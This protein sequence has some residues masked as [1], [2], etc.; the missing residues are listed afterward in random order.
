[1]HIIHFMNHFINAE[2]SP[3]H[4]EYLFVKRPFRVRL[5]HFRPQ[6]QLS[7]RVSALCAPGTPI[8]FSPPIM[9]VFESKHARCGLRRLLRKNHRR[10]LVSGGFLG[11]LHV[12]FS[13]SV[14]RI[15]ALPSPTSTA[16]AKLVPPTRS[17]R[18]R[19]SR[20]PPAPRARPKWEEGGISEGR[21]TCILYT[22]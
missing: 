19:E 11:W 7:V 10:P 20:T 4:R 21:A 16:G 15:G 18:K 8:P 17:R 9:I 1:M 2:W 6:L 14:F 13:W 22:L 5:S 12:R 3:P